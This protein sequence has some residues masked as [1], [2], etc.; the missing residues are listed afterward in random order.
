MSSQLEKL[1]IKKDEM[2]KKAKEFGDLLLKYYRDK[3]G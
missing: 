1:K 2:S 3:M